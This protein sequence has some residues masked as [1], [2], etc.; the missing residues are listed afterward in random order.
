MDKSGIVVN[1][2]S[3]FRRYHSMQCTVARRGRRRYR[4]STAARAGWQR[5]GRRAGCIGDSGGQ[6]AGSGGRFIGRLINSTT[7]DD[8]HSS[9]G[10]PGLGIRPGRGAGAP[11]RA[12][13]RAAGPAGIWTGRRAAH[14][15]PGR[16]GASGAGRDLGLGLGTG[17]GRDLGRA[18]A[19][20]PPP[21]R[22]RA[23]RHQARAPAA[24]PGR[25][26]ALGAGPGRAAGRR[27][28]DLNTIHD[29]ISGAI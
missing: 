28:S 19:G 8:H 11:H 1:S 20:P 5:Q 26:P 23:G 15:G 21:G 7:M 29:L 16:A 17:T 13:R 9:S 14:A 18:R 4:S 24:G 3:Q 2:V 6:M 22:A 25:A 10:P 12:G 27:Q